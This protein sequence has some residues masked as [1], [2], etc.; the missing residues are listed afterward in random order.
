M[1]TNIEIINEFIGRWD[2]YSDWET[3]SFFP[4]ILKNKLDE[5][6]YI[7]EE[8]LREWRDIGWI[9]DNAFTKKVK[10]IFY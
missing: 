10:M 2:Y 9:E 1:K 3:I 5:I 4:S 7:Q 6:G 8:I